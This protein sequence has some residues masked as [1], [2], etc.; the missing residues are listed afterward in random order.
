MKILF[1]GVLDVEWSTN[2]SMKHAMEGLG[3][4]V[5]DFNYR[6]IADRYSCNN[7]AN[8]PLGKWVDKSAS[9]LR[10]GK[11]PLRLSWYFKRNG[12]KQMNQALLEIYPKV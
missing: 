1:V 12:R 8:K 6:T 10:S 2:C 9:F 7:V 4:T 3:H 5:V 11:I